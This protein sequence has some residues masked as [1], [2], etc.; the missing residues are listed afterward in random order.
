MSR[1][2]AAS[3]VPSPSLALHLPAEIWFMILSGL[4]YTQ[5]RKAARICK[6]CQQYTRASQFDAVLFRLPP[7]QAALPCDSTIILHPFLC[8]VTGALNDLADARFDG[9]FDV[10]EED[11][12]SRDNLPNSSL[13]PLDYSSALAEYATSPA[14][15]KV[16]IQHV[17]GKAFVTKNSRGVTVRQVLDRIARPWMTWG[18]VMA[19]GIWG[20]WSRVTTLGQNRKK[21]VAYEEHFE[22]VV[23]EYDPHYESDCDS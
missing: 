20:G 18:A 15:V 13:R 12:S 19:W 10:D 4:N 17:I 11:D 1:L 22:D 16:V 2:R 21:L 9:D 3:P 6:T 7:P 8:K 14:S 23:N 5:L